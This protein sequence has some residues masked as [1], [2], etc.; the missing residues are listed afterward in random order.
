MIKIDPNKQYTPKELAYRKLIVK[1]KVENVDTVYHWLLDMIKDGKL[2]AVSYG[3]GE[4]VPRMFIW[5]H[6]VIRFLKEEMGM[7]YE[8]ATAKA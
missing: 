3:R 1:P 5:G 4:K 8:Q 6:E 7:D 2:T